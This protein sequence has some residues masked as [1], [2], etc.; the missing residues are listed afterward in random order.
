MVK[1]REQ[2]LKDY[3]DKRKRR[4]AEVSFSTKSFKTFIDKPINEII[5]G[6][7]YSGTIGKFPISDGNYSLT[8]NYSLEAL[9]E[10]SPTMRERYLQKQETEF[11]EKLKQDETEEQEQE[12]RD[13]SEDSENGPE[14]PSST[15]PLDPPSAG[16]TLC[17]D[18]EEPEGDSLQTD[19]PDMDL[20]PRN[21]LEEPEGGSRTP[22][23]QPLG[24]FTTEE[25]T[26]KITPPIQRPR[27]PIPEMGDDP[28]PEI[29][30]IPQK[31]LRRRP[32]PV[33]ER[34]ILGLE[35][36]SPRRLK[37]VRRK[38]YSQRDDDFEEYQRYR[39]YME[40][41]RRR[42]RRSYYSDSEDSDEE[43]APGRGFFDHPRKKTPDSDYD[44][45]D[46]PYMRHQK[47]PSA[48]PNALNRFGIPDQ[49]RPKYRFL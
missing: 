1:S 46:N 49:N 39:S 41:S 35:E 29:R 25:K 13:T 47:Q 48:N 40:K 33:P 11:I 34:E 32:D 4:R 21:T 14:K 31:E 3:N 28:L 42:K 27:D 26:E 19:P 43:F 20:T 44:M 17:K 18:H 37:R 7:G 24:G 36:M 38:D 10:E 23:L 22:L 5:L 15:S 30:S 9:S 2:I 6:H 45:Y 16:E 12:V 8:V